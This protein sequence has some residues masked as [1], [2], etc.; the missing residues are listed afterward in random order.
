MMDHWSHRPKRWQGEHVI[1]RDQ[2]DELGTPLKADRVVG[3]SETSQRCGISE[4][5]P[6]GSFNSTGWLGDRAPRS[7]AKFEPLT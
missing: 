5:Q 6:Q 4:R 3:E 2:A 7:E 1:D